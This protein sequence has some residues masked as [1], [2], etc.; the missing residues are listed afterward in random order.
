[1]VCQ[2]LSGVTL[3]MTKPARYLTDGVFDVKF[4]LVVTG[5]I[6]TNFNQRFL[7]RQI[8][9]WEAAGAISV[10]GTRFAALTGVVW[11]GVLIM[12]RLTAYLGS[13]Y[14]S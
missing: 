9:V 14:I 8:P 1:V 7:R 11:A 4:S 3:W 13:L 6:I 12:G 5:V 2:V 10:S